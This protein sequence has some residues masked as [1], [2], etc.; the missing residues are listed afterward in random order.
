MK[1]WLLVALLFLPAPV[2][3]ATSASGSFKSL[4]QVVR[5]APAD[6]T[7]P[8]RFSSNRLRLELADKLPGAD[9]NLALDNRWLYTSPAA[10]VPL[11]GEN[12]NRRLDLQHD[13]ARGQAS[14][15]Q[16]QIDRL[17][18]Q[19]S[20]HG[21]DWSVGRQPIGFGRIVIFSPLDIIAPFAPEALDTDVRPGV[22]ALRVVHYFGLGGQL[23]ATTVFGRSPKYNSY[24]G[25]F[26]TNVKQI[27]LLA[28][29]GSLRDRPMVGLGAAGSLGGLGLK[30][31][32]SFYRGRDLSRPE[33]DPARHFTI[34]ALEG[35]Y[36]L[37]NGLVLLGE[38]LY[39][40][41]GS[42]D[43]AS[44]P[45]ALQ[46][47]PYREGMTFL[48]GRQYLLLGPSYQLHP[49]VE[50]QGLAIW[51]L[52][53]DSFLARPLVNLSLGDNLSLQLFWAFA[54]GQ[55]PAPPPLPGFPPVVRSEFG[56]QGDGGG[57]FFSWYY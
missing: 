19:G 6:L 17:Q 56:S 16:L 52:Q 11:P 51:N 37:E 14:A 5:E 36:R 13:I 38:Y 26:S 32:A 31:E 44:Y 29:S 8:L 54:F 35:W 46:R 57:L 15:A 21:L 40:G 25:T 41:P 18:L 22:D 47:A 23:G 20:S 28:N 30:A 55:K 24:L 4:D 45:L 9:F 2:L 50:L 3:A 42:D 43:P 39:N 10:A 34:A 33:G 48:A 1:N 27:D 49:L 12:L 7:G 53:D